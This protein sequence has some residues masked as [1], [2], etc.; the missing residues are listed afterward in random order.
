MHAFRFVSRLAV[1][2][3]ISFATAVM[4]EE[5][6]FAPPDNLDRGPRSYNK[7]FPS[8]FDESPAWSARADVF[9]L[10]P[11]FT[12]EAS[13]QMQKRI[14]SFLEK[15]HI[16]LAVGIGAVQ[17]DHVERTEGE[18]GLGVE[19][20][21]RPNK[22][23]IIFSRLKR[24]GCDVQYV[25]MD[26]PLS[27]GHHYR[28]KNACNFSIQEVAKRV[29][30]TAM[31]IR[32]V[33]PKVK[34]VDYESVASTKPA[35]EW[36]IDLQAWLAAYRQAAGEL[37]DAMVF[38]V[39]WNKPWLDAVRPG[40]ELLHRNGMRAG[41]FLTGTGPGKSDAEAVAAYRKNIDSVDAAKLPLDIVVIANWTPHP[42]NNLPES[43]PNS[44]SGVFHYYMT[45][46]AR[47][48]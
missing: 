47:A 33:Y 15:R 45:K 2:L 34:F 38:D 20:Y 24:W 5:V 48:K 1:V 26:E 39:D 9:V 36:L 14:S 32:K 4:A 25:A 40:I 11:K 8:L 18:C 31:E 46:H 41:I 16:A 23:Q 29:A 7:D 37:P 44:L 17:M 13:E 21:T 43:D 27:F 3:L 42:A 19:G 10:S 6:W 12:E 35:K 28:H 30:A 22:N